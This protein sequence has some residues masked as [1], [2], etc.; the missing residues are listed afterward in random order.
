MT[1]GIDFTAATSINSNV[2]VEVIVASQTVGH[3]AQE[4]R[5]AEHLAEFAPTVLGEQSQNR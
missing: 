5:F 3:E 1:D 4:L 2:T